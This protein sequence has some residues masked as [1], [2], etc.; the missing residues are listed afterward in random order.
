MGSTGTP[1]LIDLLLILEQP[2]KAL[3]TRFATW[4]PSF[5]GYLTL[6][7]FS[8]MPY[9]ANIPIRVLRWLKFFVRFCPA[10]SK[11]KLAPRPQEFEKSCPLPPRTR[12]LPSRTRPAP[13]FFGLK[14]AAVRKLLK[15]HN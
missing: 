4:R 11:F 3:R 10:P 13:H 14:P 6:Q 5:K 1:V 15:T 7:T 9:S 2:T 8:S 12:T